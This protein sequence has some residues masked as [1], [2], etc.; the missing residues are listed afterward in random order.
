MPVPKTVLVICSQV[1]GRDF[2]RQENQIMLKELL[3]DDYSAEFMGE[4]PNDLPVTKT[5]N[6]V[7]FA[8]CNVIDWVFSDFNKQTEMIEVNQMETGMATL[9]KMLKKDGFVI[10]VEHPRYIELCCGQSFHKLSIPLE[11]LN[12]LPTTKNYAQVKQRILNMWYNYFQLVQIKNYYAYQVHQPEYRACIGIIKSGP[13][14]GQMCGV[15]GG[16]FC[17]RHG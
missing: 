2:L 10:F 17:G 9:S 8:G 6:A 12:I 3:G 13:R 1:D 4:Y 7:L 15:K 5:F 11:G 14:K 16:M